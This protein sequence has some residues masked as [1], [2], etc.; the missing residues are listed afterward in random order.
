MLGD[1]VQ[2]KSDAAHSQLTQLCDRPLPR[3][4]PRLASLLFASLH[5]PVLQE[6]DEEDICPICQED[7]T[8]EELKN[9]LL[10]Y[11]EDSCGSNFHVKCLRMFATHAKSEKK[12]VL[13][14]MCRG[15]W[16]ELPSEP[17]RKPRF[18]VNM[19]TVKCKS[20]KIVCRGNFYR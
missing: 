20:C 19:P 3:P 11:C 1:M 8:P 12:K 5:S 13:C 2:P 10:C 15:E 9:D 14:P 6:L 7:M 4:L 16:G 18:N 17:V